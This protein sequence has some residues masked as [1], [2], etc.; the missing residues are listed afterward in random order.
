MK[1]QK[2]F[3]R[4]VELLEG[5]KSSGSNCFVGALCIGVVQN[6][7]LRLFLG[8]LCPLFFFSKLQRLSVGFG[9]GLVM[10]HEPG[11]STYVSKSQVLLEN[12]ISISNK[13][14]SRGHG[15]H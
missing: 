11:L 1:E 14:L 9:L 7:W 3:N 5:E 6:G 13:L 4:I 8:L 12:D 10:D 15:V 2:H